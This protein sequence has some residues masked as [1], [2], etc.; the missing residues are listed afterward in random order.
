MKR[1]FRVAT[2]F[3]GAAACAV[4]LAPAAEAVPV[5]PGTTSRITPDTT[6]RDCTKTFTSS[7]VL[8]YSSK[9]NHSVNACIAGIGFVYFGQGKRFASYCAGAYSGFMYVNGTR[10]PFTEGSHPTYGAAISAVS[11]TRDNHRGLQCS[12]APR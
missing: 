6:A 11:I 1:S 2:V 5:A 7:V 10:R 12:A 3:T 4:A 8:Y 9:Q